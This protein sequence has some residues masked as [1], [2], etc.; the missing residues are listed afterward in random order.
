[1]IPSAITRRSM[2]ASGLA[3]ASAPLFGSVAN[4]LQVECPSEPQAQVMRPRPQRA[5]SLRQ[6][7]A[8]LAAG[9]PARLEGMTRVDGYVIQQENQD[10]V[11]WGLAERGQAEL[12]VADLVVALRAAHKRYLERRNG[13]DYIITPLISIDPNPEVF[14]R[15]RALRVTDP[16]HQRKHAELCRTPQKVRIE[17]MPRHTRL[18]KV[19]VD[20]DYRMK[21]VAQGTVVLP[22]SSPFPAAD[23]VRY[24]KWREDALAERPIEGAHNTRYWFEAGRFSYQ[25]DADTVFLDSTQIVL[26]DEDQR[27]NPGALVAS[28]RTDAITRAFACAWSERMEDTFRAE[29]IWRDM[30]DIFRLFALARVIADRNAFAQASLSGEMLLDRYQVPH[31]EVPAALP[32]LGRWDESEE[33]NAAGTGT[34]RYG[35]WICG[36]VSVGFARPLEAKPDAGET[37]V[38]GRIVLASRRD[39]NAITWSVAPGS[40]EQGE[41]DLH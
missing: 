23:K 10:V 15:L 35:G 16:A 41:P 19:L 7:S 11:L 18:A 26:R 33:R 5:V 27:L 37:K 39:A 12:H 36:G 2:L 1:M 40:L 6:L 32:G 25:Y 9:G 4:S 3:A 24:A 28:G 13:V 21:M 20:A 8:A 29:P 17:G 14:Q 38:S 34:T 22:I 31:V 30:H